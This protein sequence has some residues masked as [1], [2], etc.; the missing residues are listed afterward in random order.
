MLFLN[1][2]N[3]RLYFPYLSS[4]ENLGGFTVF[5]L[6]PHSGHVS[7]NVYLPQLGH[8]LNNKLSPKIGHHYMPLSK[9]Q[10]S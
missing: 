1:L 2:F 4:G 5:V 7:L 9:I 8:F 6:L 10:Y 3:I